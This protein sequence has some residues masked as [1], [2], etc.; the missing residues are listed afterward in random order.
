MS[1]VKLYH[2][3]LNNIN[4][5]AVI[6]S[7]CIIHDFAWVSDGV[8]IGDRVKIQAFVFIPSGVSINNDV[9]IG[10]RVTFLNDLYPPAKRED[11]RPTVV[12]KGASI[13]GGATI[14]PGIII[15]EGAL[16]GAGAVV[17]KNV[18]ANGIVAGNPA[19]FLRYKD[20][21]K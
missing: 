17:T 21:K 19:K 18:P 16:V 20:D 7:E 2:P 11:W 5:K 3:E 1:F 8:N 4:P 15:G 13:G 10:P 12:G 9:F 6:G 14:L